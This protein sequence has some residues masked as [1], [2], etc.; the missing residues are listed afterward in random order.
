MRNRR[1]HVSSLPL[2]LIN[3]TFD[4][5]KN[6]TK[7]KLYLYIYIYKLYCEFLKEHAMKVINF[8]KKKINIY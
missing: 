5:V 7:K 8:K 4:K 2:K 1:T 6:F 3:V